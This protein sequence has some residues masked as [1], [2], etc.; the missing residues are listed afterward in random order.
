VKDVISI[1]AEILKS[2]ILSQIFIWSG[3]FISKFENLNIL[4]IGNR[5][6]FILFSILFSL[7]SSFIFFI[8]N[9]LISFSINFFA[10]VKSS[11]VINLVKLLVHQINLSIDFANI[12]SLYSHNF[13]IVNKTHVHILVFNHE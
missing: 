13:G 6:T 7:I 9:S 12:F 10:L 8:A 1:S 11:F 3:T 4:S 2:L 5:S